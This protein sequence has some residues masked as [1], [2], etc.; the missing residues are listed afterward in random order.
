M[1]ILHKDKSVK[2]LGQVYAKRSTFLVDESKDKKNSIKAV[3]TKKALQLVDK[4]RVR[5]STQGICCISEELKEVI[6]AAV[7]DD[8]HVD[9]HHLFLIALLSIQ[10]LNKELAKVRRNVKELDE[11]LNNDNESISFLE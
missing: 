9:Y 7:V 8:T 3:N 1:E 5:T 6:P 2:F 11:S 4:L 10:Q